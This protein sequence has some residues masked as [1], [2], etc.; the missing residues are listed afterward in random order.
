VSRACC[1]THTG[2]GVIRWRIVALLR[3][4][5][6]GRRMGW[7]YSNVNGDS[8]SYYMPKHGS[9][10]EAAEIES[11]NLTNSLAFRQVLQTLGLPHQLGQF[12]ARFRHLHPGEHIIKQGCKAFES[13][14]IEVAQFAA[15]WTVPFC[16]HKNRDSPHQTGQDSDAHGDYR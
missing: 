5:I 11:S 8:N 6:A 10:L 3:A 1:Y 16:R 4:L 9:W 15:K 13:T 2:T 7:A 14:I 12:H